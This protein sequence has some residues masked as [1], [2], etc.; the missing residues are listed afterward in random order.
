VSATLDTILG[1]IVAA[2]GTIAYPMWRN[3]KKDQNAAIE[4]D[5][6]DSRSVAGM[7]KE[8]RD[9]LQIRLDTT[10]A[11][12]QRQIHDLRV[13]YDEALAR[14]E[15]KWK[16]QHDA[17]QAQIA[18]LRTEVYGLYRQLNQHRPGT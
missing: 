7:F 12:H 5:A 17:D 13:E 8:E 6:L 10:A 1:L 14:A 4:K 2:I 16:V 3:R 18:D 11:A 9:R 15:A